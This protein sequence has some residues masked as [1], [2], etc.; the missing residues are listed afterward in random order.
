MLGAEHSLGEAQLGDDLE[1]GAAR[2]PRR[3]A[4]SA[5]EGAL[6]AEEGVEDVAD[7][8]PERV[9][10]PAVSVA[11]VA[12]AVVAGPLLGVAQGLV[13]ARHLFELVLGLG[14]AGVCVRVQ[15]AGP[16][17]IGPLDLVGCG[18]AGDAEQLVE[19]GHV[20]G[21]SLRRGGFRGGG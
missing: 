13:G 10:A 7:P 20:R 14:V 19:V 21:I 15:G 3:S 12:E 18:V 4:R 1:I 16:L 9:A 2:W 8:S 5:A 11:G 6:A 17:A